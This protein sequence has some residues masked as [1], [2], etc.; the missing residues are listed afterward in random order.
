M[1]DKEVEKTEDSSEVKPKHRVKP[2]S[3]KNS[4]NP[5]LVQMKKRVSGF[6]HKSIGVHKSQVDYYISQ[7]W[8]CVN[9]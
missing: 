4:M 3:K 2:K 6:T 8:S 7:G 9:K 1:K 5:N